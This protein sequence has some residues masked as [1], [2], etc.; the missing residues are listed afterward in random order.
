MSPDENKNSEENSNT[1][2][3]DS[4]DVYV[5]GSNSSHQ[6]AAGSQ[7]KVLAPKLAPAFTN[8]QQVGISIFYFVL[9]YC[10]IIY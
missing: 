4:C 5:W 3:Q 2:S 8:V 9:E 10:T 1:V 7:E 6:L